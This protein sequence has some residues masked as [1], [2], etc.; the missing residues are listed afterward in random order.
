MVDFTLAI[1]YLD[2]FFDTIFSIL[3][4]VLNLIMFAMIMGFTF[5]FFRIFFKM[6]MLFRL[7]STLIYDVWIKYNRDELG[8]PA[9]QRKQTFYRYDLE[10]W[11][12][13][14]A[15]FKDATSFW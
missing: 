11:R 9:Y 5:I 3:A 2:K 12:S 10:G 14:S 15:M 6:F 13:I 4:P 8:L 7:L 1:P